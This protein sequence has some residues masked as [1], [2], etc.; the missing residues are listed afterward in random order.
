M[1][2]SRA[3]RGA[4]AGLRFT[5]SCPFLHPYDFMRTNRVTTRLVPLV[6]FLQIALSTG[7]RAQAFEGVITVRL[8]GAPRGG[9]PTE[10]DYMAKGGNV[11]LNSVSPLGNVGVVAVPGEGRVYVLLE[12]QRMYM[13]QPINDLRGARAPGA[14]ATAARAQAAPPPVIKRTGRKETIAGHACE[15]VLVT[16]AGDGE[17]DMCMARALGPFISPASALGGAGM[18]AWQRALATDGG[19]PLKVT[20]PDGTTLLEV[21]RIVRRKLPASNFTVPDDFVKMDRPPGRDIRR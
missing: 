2:R 18:P 15:H 6:G 3:G 8:G 19:F 4:F 10:M 9:Q 17:I 13:E 7:A 12:A 16:S 21:I 14:S 1:L 20:R 11:R 5:R